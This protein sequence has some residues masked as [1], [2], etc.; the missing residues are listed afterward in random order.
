MPRY[1][2]RR[3]AF[4]VCK[5]LSALFYKIF[6]RSVCRTLSDQSCGLDSTKVVNHSGDYILEAL[7][8]CWTAPLKPVLKCI[9]I[10]A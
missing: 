2:K 6:S 9:A 7:E 5:S 8:V 4:V 3:I 1:S 10:G